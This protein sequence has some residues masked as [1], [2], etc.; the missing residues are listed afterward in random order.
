LR[1]GDR[2][3]VKGLAGPGMAVKPKVVPMPRGNGVQKANVQREAA[4]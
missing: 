4:R 2:V 3:V 1:P